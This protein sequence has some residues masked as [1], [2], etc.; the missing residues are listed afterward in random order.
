MFYSTFLALV[1]TRNLN[2]YI[3]VGNGKIYP[4]KM[5]KKKAQFPFNHCL[6]QPGKKC[7]HNQLN[8]VCLCH[9]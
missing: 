2:P 8:I 5:F 4:I 7:V 3:L 6:E 1:Q 9:L